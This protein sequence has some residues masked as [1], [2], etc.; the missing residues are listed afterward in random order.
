MGA[1]D[2]CRILV[3]KPYNNI[4]LEIPRRRR[5]DNMRVDLQ[6]MACWGEDWFDLALDRYRWRALVNATMNLRIP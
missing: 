1:E 5:D 6:E 2:M 4:P 3:E